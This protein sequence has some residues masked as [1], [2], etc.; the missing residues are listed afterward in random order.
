MST[1]FTPEEAEKCREAFCRFDKDRNGTIDSHELRAALESFGQKPSEE[2]IFCMISEVDVDSNGV[3]DFSEFVRVLQAQKERAAALSSESDMGAWRGR[4]Q[5]ARAPLH[6]AAPCPFSIPHPLATRHRPPLLRSRR[7]H[8]VRR[9]A[10]QERLCG[11]GPPGAHCQGGLWAH[12]RGAFGLPQHRALT[13]RAPRASPR[14]APHRAL[15]RPTTPA[16]R[17]RPPPQD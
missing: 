6:T 9:A 5:R 14:P 1:A 4:T 7:L 13:R 8:C 3:V 17:S 10:R 2:E 15:T 16:L 12:V 11:A